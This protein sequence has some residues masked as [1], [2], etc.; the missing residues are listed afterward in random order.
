MCFRLRVRELSESRTKSLLSICKY[1]ASQPSDFVEYKWPFECMS[2]TCLDSEL[3]PGHK[4]GQSSQPLKWKLAL[5][6]K[7]RVSFLEM[8]I[9]ANLT[10]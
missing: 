6:S 8:F 5:N 1:H 3:Q 9:Y 2:M 4:Y 10:M 7:F